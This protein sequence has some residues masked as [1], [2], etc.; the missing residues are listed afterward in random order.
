MSVIT[1]EEDRLFLM[2]Q[3]GELKGYMAGVEMALA[4]TKELVQKR[5]ELEEFRHFQEDKG[6]KEAENTTTKYT[7]LMHLSDKSTSGTENPDE[8]FM[9]L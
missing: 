7:N 2:D 1:I 9:K 6:K 3:R 5:K 8:E 4:K